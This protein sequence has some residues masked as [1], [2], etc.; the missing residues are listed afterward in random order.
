MNPDDL[1]AYQSD[2]RLITVFSERIE[3]RDAVDQIAYMVA[4]FTL[5]RRTFDTKFRR[6]VNGRTTKNDALLPLTE[7]DLESD[8]Q[9]DLHK[10]LIRT[11]NE[12]VTHLGGKHSVEHRHVDG[13]HVVTHDRPNLSNE[14]RLRQPLRNLVEFW[15]SKLIEKFP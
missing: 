3:Q 5:Y 9:L 6:S 15:Q 11:A 8:E 2:L 7:A 4:V 10:W 13:H 1:Y 14:P 12:W